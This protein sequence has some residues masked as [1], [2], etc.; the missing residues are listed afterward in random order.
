M[1]G[2]CGRVNPGKALR[3]VVM[4][5]Q[6]KMP[7]RWGQKA[8][9]QDRVLFT[10]KRRRRGC[11]TISP[12]GASSRSLVLGHR[13]ARWGTGPLTRGRLAEWPFFG[14]NFLRQ[15]GQPFCHRRWEFGRMAGGAAGLGTRA[16]PLPGQGLGLGFWSSARDRMRSD[17]K[18][19]SPF[20]PFHVITSVAF[21]PG[22]VE[23]SG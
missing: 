6:R 17:A 9:G 15:K 14:R 19:S 21:H 2:W 5:N 13:Q 7:R 3:N 8:C 23:D 18:R 20:V 22:G 11:D 4:S 1:P 16:P 12:P 10:R